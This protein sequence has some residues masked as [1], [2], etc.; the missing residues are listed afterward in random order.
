MANYMMQPGDKARTATTIVWVEQLEKRWGEHWQKHFYGYLADLRTQVACSPVH[1]QDTYT[2]TD[3]KNWVRRHIDPDTGDVATEYTNQQPRVG[4][5][6]KAHIHLIVI[7][8][9]PQRREDFSE[10]FLDLVWIHPNKWQHVV[11]LDTLIR[12]LAHM[13]NPEKHKY[14][15]FDVMGF[16]GINLKPLT[17][18]KSDEYSKATA[19]FFVQSYIEDNHIR[20][21]HVLCKWAKAFGDY[22]VYACVMG[23]TPTW[24]AYFSSMRLEKMDKDAKR[25][26]KAEREATAA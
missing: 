1:D 14:S 16:G 10:M 4:D 7:V 21:Y 17:I 11:H 13:D 26:A 12:Y 2:E 23:R 5:P 9:G 24:V 19:M 15:V 25:K 22:D 20:Y 18:Q 3:V 6:K 8:K